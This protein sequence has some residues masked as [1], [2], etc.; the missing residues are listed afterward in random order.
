V[1]GGAV[2]KITVMGPAAATEGD[3]EVCSRCGPRT[4][5]PV[6]LRPARSM[7]R[8]PLVECRTPPAAARVEEVP[9]AGAAP[10]KGMVAAAA[11]SSASRSTRVTDN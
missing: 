8:S 9:A 7:T 5:W 11:P 3:F 6:G 10:A 1:H 2:S 4:V